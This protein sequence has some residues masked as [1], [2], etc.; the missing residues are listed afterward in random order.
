MKPSRTLEEAAE[1]FWSKVDKTGNCWLWTAAKNKSGYGNFRSNTFFKGELL[2]HRVS[3]RLAWGR[4][5]K[6]GVL[7]KCDTPACVN[8]SHLY[9]GSQRDNAADMM[10]R[11]RHGS[12]TKGNGYLPRGEGHHYYRVGK[13]LTR[14]EA[15]QIRRSS[16]S[17]A[18]IGLRF[19]VDR[20][21]VCKI[22]HGVCWRE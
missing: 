12:A 22:K 8:P 21:M 13:K 5:P 6:G 17:N 16:G 15:L 2:A 19:G 9:E 3:F 14:E 1:R 11:G 18:A 20:S 10:A 7:H 4:A